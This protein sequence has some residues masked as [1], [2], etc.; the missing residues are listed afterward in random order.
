MPFDESYSDS[1]DDSLNPKDLV[2]EERDTSGEREPRN[3]HQ[4]FRGL[5]SHTSH[6]CDIMDAPTGV[7]LVKN[8]LFSSPNVQA[9]VS[10][11][12]KR[13]LEESKNGSS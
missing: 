13:S 6:T 1:N 9:P 12:K 4:A 11:K 2:F 8:Q 10:S 5:K 3:L 7:H